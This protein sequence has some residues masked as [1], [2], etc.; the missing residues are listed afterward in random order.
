M[1]ELPLLPMQK[2]GRKE[3]RKRREEKRDWCRRMMGEIGRVEKMER[4]NRQRGA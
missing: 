4:R 1:E 3:G 2:E